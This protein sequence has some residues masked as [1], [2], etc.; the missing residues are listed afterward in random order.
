MN[1]ALGGGGQFGAGLLESTVEAP[2]RI[3]IFFFE[4]T[5]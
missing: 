1:R 3:E 4:D 5:P 2:E